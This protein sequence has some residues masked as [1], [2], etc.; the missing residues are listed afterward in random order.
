MRFSLRLLA[1]LAALAL[2]PATAWAQRMPLPLKEIRLDQVAQDT[3]RTHMVDDTME[4]VWVIPPVYWHVSAAQQQGLSDADRKQFIAQLDDYLLIAMVRGKV[5]IAGIDEFADSDTMFSDM[6]FLD[7][8]GTAHAP[9][10]PTSIPAQ[11]K[12]LLSILRPVMA[13]MLGPMG[14]NMHFAVLD[15]RDAKGKLL[16]DP[17]T[18]GRVQVRT[19]LDTYSFRTP[20][21]SLLPARHDARTGERF[22]GDYLFNPYTGGALQGAAQPR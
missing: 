22:P 4:L 15:A 20:L 18:D 17:M 16:F 9:M 6:R 5:G 3:Q 19:S 1:A 14:D 8:T 12:N 2:L 10:A 7:A 13:N 21:G 11:L